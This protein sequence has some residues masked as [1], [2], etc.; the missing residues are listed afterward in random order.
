MFL[1]HIP[2]TQAW[3]HYFALYKTVLSVV[4]LHDIFKKSLASPTKR[5]NTVAINPV[6]L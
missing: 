4:P 3:L 5:N 6:A 1:A 2:L